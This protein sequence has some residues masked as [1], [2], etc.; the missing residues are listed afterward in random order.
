MRVFKISIKLP[1]E[2]EACSQYLLVRLIR[3][4]SM[5]LILD[6]I[7]EYLASQRYINIAL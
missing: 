4:I 5:S 3:S 2:I 6:K 1:S 7:I